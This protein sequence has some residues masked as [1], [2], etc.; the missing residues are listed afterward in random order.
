MTPHE[1]TM[2][3]DLVDAKHAREWQDRTE[4]HLRDRLA[5]LNPHDKIQLL[6]KIDE[7]LR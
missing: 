1:Q 3:N 5:V 6:R 2:F 4:A 7:V